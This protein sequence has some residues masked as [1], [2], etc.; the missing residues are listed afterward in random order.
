MVRVRHDGGVPPFRRVGRYSFYTKYVGE[1]Y[2][3]YRGKGIWRGAPPP[4]R[5]VGYFSCL[6]GLIGKMYL[7]GGTPMKG[8]TPSG[9][10]GTFS[11][12][13]RY[14]GKGTWGTGG[15]VSEGA[16]PPF[17]ELDISRFYTI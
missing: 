7:N 13:T 11:V 4:F 5:R 17:V 8:G 15:T 1:M 9:T 14:R 2:L 3:I 12:Y 10:L 16:V 6:Y